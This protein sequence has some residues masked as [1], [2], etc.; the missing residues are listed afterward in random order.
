MV[1]KKKEIPNDLASSDQSDEEILAVLGFRSF[2]TTKNKDH[3]CTSV[4]YTS[5]LKPKRKFSSVL[6]RKSVRYSKDA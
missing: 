2:A 5:Q 1:K 3:S 6:N 4:E